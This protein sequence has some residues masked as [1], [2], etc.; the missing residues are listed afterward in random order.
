VLKEDTISI[1]PIY[2][3]RRFMIRFIRSGIIG[4]TI[5]SRAAKL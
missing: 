3:I 1:S 5:E 2:K 4:F